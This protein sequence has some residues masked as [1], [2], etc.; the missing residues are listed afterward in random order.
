LL[1][2]NEKARRGLQD[3]QL[4]CRLLDENGI[5]YVRDTLD[6]N[7]DVV[8]VAGGDGTVTWSIPLALNRGVPVAIIPLGTFNDLAHALDIPMDLSE[9][10]RLVLKGERRKID[11]GR[12]NGKYFVNESSVGLSSRIARR[13]TPEIKQR[14]GFLGVIGTTLQSIR[15]TRPFRVELAYDGHREQ[16]RSVQLTIA[17]NKRFGGLIERPDAAIDDGWL[18]LYSVEAQTWWQF[19]GIVRKIVAR[20]PTSGEGLRT[21]RAARFD[22]HTRHAHHIEAD[23]EPAGLTPAIFEILPR[24][25]EVLVPNA[26]S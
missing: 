4:V 18:D 2:L 12:V 9:A 21:R 3:A 17:N 1:I 11:V 23:G 8:I 15:K 13:Q 14:L 5:D 19:F 25:L 22:V 24:A 26:V 7:V 6:R 16:F 20:D 10:C